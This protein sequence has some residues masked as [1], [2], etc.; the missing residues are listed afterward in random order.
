MFLLIFVVGIMKINCEGIVKNHPRP[1]FKS[2]M[3]KKK[4]AQV[5]DFY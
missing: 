3:M 2:G 1:K 4:R 5:T